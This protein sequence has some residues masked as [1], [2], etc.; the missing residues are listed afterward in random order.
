MYDIAQTNECYLGYVG[1]A[2][3]WVHRFVLS[4]PHN[5]VLYATA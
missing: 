3:D 5:S 4:A 2:L 1:L